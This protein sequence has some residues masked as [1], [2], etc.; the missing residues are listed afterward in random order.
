MEALDLRG[1]AAIFADAGLAVPSFPLGPDGAKIRFGLLDSDFPYMLD[2]PQSQIER[3]L[4]ARALELGAEVRW[5]ATVAAVTQ[6]DD[7]VTVTLADGSQE[8]ADYVVACDGV[9]SFVRNDLAIPF[10]GIHNPGAVILA[11]LHLDG[12]PMDSAYG[13]LSRNG[14]LLV[15]PF[16]DGSCRLVLYDFSRGNIPV[17]EPV[18]F[19]EVTASLHRVV[20]QDFGP[21]DMAWSGRY[22]SESRQTPDYRSGRVLLAGDAAHA[23]SPA[24]AQGMNTGLQDSVN[25]G[26]KLAAAVN[27]W[28]PD[29]L[30]DSYNAERHPV[31]ASVLALSGRQFRLN[32]AKSPV[33]RLRRWAV[34]RL[35]TPLPFVQ[36]RL[37]RDYSGLSISYP[38]APSGAE[39]GGPPAH[40]LAGARLPRG[41][42]TLA[43]ST[44]ASLYELFHDG[45]F[46]LLESSAAAGPPVL[47]DRIRTVRYTA[48]SP[49]LPA[50]TL[51]RPDGYVAWATDTRDPASRAAAVASAARLWCG[52]R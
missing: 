29:W 34:Y 12:L 19:A 39:P 36:A 35:V 42:L 49:A 32:T 9:H 6:D 31:G 14:M 23:H 24:G 1:Q 7:G 45:R 38:P 10:P 22:Q 50:A 43:D 2:L 18:T 33:R 30:L 28:G 21:R 27:G 17:T 47:A 11:D 25:L 52:S 37:A 3:L 15:F 20:G 46:V 41:K 8:R 26:W 51:V 4:L 5:S 48:C 13:D 40:P 16:R 44:T